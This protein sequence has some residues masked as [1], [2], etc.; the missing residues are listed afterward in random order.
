MSIEIIKYSNK[1]RCT[2]PLQPLYQDEA[3]FQS[4]DEYFY[5]LIVLSKRVQSV[6][7]ALLMF[8][9]ISIVLDEIATAR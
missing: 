1:F 3:N 7:L 4:V 6:I 2:Q 9:S 8:I 5:K